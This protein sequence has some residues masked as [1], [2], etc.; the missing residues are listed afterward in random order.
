MSALLDHVWGVSPAQDRVWAQVSGLSPHLADHR[1]FMVLQAFIDDSY[2]R[3]GIFALGGYVATAENWANF[4]KE[5]EAML[6]YGTRAKNGKFHFKMSEMAAS[7]RMDRVPAFYKI[8]E[9]YVMCA[10]SLVVNIP[11]IVRAQNRIW[12]PNVNINYGYANKPHWLTYRALLDMF[13][14]HRASGLLDDTVPPGQKVDFYFDNQSG[15]AEIIASWDDYVANRGEGITELY[16]A[17]P[18][19]ENDQEFLPLQAADF[20]A[21]W[22]RRAYETRAVDRIFE[23]LDFGTWK[24]ERIFNRIGGELDEELLSRSFRNFLWEL[25]KERNELRIIYDVKFSP[26]ALLGNA[27]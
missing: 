23:K 16:G 14:Q 3:N 10:V 8:I 5:W 7:G 4:S 11:D 21:W 15:K 2:T 9:K 26:V 25:L 20:W 27:P 22:I 18:R 17:T 1:L 6:P 12:S 24:G 19:F 13:H